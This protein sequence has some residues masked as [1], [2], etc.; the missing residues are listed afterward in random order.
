[1]NTRDILA[2]NIKALRMQKGLTQKALADLCQVHQNYICEIEQGKR[3]FSIH[4]LDQFAEVFE[5]P[6]HELLDEQLMQRMQSANRNE[7]PYCPM[8]GAEG[9]VFYQ[10]GLVAKTLNQEGLQDKAE[11]MLKRVQTSGSYEEALC[12][13]QEYVTPCTQEEL[14][15]HACMI[16][17]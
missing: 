3:N 7:K 16:Q 11:E 1:M 8:I 2:E 4:L 15:E 17:K 12:I 9:N 10:M 5:I 13:M 6:V 14:V